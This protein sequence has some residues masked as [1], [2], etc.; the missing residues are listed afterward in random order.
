LLHLLVGV[1]VVLEQEQLVAQLVVRVAVVVLTEVVA[2]LELLVKVV[3]V[4]QVLLRILCRKA[5]AVALV[6]LVATA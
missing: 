6:Q 1:L 5:A 2:V 3:M 4:V